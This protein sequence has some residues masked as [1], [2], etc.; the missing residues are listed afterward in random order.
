M[1]ECQYSV[2]LLSF[3]CAFLWYNKVTCFFKKECAYNNIIT[4]KIKL[5]DEKLIITEKEF[6]LIT[7]IKYI[8]YYGAR[9]FEPIICN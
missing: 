1:I 5:T 4:Q 2:Y 8:A 7:D 6:E 3:F 9:E